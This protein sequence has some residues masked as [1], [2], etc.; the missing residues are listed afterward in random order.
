M[1][2]TFTPKASSS[3][4]AL[5]NA[6]WTPPACYYA[7]LRTP[8]E[9]ESYWADLMAIRGLIPE[10]QQLLYQSHDDFL[11]EHEDYNLDQQGEGA[12][13]G[14]VRNRDYPLDEQLT[15][16]FRT[17]WVAYGDPPPV[18]P[19]VIQPENLA[20]LAWAETRV[21][22][23]EVSI[24]PEGAQKVNLPMWVWLDEVDFSPVSV[25]AE[26]DG[27]G[28]WAETTATPKE[29]TLEPGTGD[30]STHPASGTCVIRDG[31]VGEPYVRGRSGEDPPCGITY[32]RATHNTGANALRA[33]L[34]WEVTWVDYAG[35]GGTLADGT[36]SS[37]ID[38]TVDEVQ[39]IVR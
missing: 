36:L 16:E 14:V 24:N 2:I 8:E 25:R 37:T 13:W 21:P 10:D 6:T 9:M 17:Y 27:Y 4:G 28:I 3:E 26:L 23:T 18:E 20:E 33:T 30:A 19:G 7:P 11:E 31:R 12:F 38:I 15:C 34:T 35:N 39:T 29:L 32:G 5:V 1:R 22:D